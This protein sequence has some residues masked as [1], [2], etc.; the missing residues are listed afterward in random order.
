[1][2]ERDAWSI[3]E[4]GKKAKADLALGDDTVLSS[5]LLARFTMNGV[6][7]HLKDLTS[8]IG[9]PTFGAASDD[10]ET[11]DPSLL[12]MGMGSHLSPE[13][14]VVRALTEVA[15]SRLTQIHGAREDTVDAKGRQQLGYDRVKRI[16]RMWFDS[17]GTERNV[18]SIVALDTP[19]IYDDIQVLLSQLNERGFKKVI[20]VDLTRKELGIPVVRIIIPGMEVFAMD[21]ERVGPRLIGGLV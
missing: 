14:A 13:I 18:G 16:N 4:A 9:V 5:E 17:S 21:E 20:A 2:I 6:E 8:D 3:C 11:R 15:Q 10:I 1:V 19:D 12:T 7:I